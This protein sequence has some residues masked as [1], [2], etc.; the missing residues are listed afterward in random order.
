M[1]ATIESIRTK[2]HK[3]HATLARHQSLMLKK[4]SLRDKAQDE[5]DR[6]WLDC[7]IEE[8]EERIDATREKI[9][10]AAQALEAAEVAKEAKTA[11]EAAMPEQ[12]RE[13]RDKLASEWNACDLNQRRTMLEQGESYYRINGKVNSGLYRSYI[14]L[15]SMSEADIRKRNHEYA[16]AAVENLIARVEKAVGTPQGY[17]R[18]YVTKGNW[19]EGGSA[20]NGYVSG[21][22]GTVEVRSILAG[23]HN[24]QRLH[25]RV[26]VIKQ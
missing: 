26:L 23:G 1:A 10:K 21:D 2:I 3:L 5:N 14:E 20:I 17:S 18:L 13:Y 8:L 24:I 11:K 16:T 7:D 22:R 19:M 6:F 15:T 4:Q 9:A 25:V 12:L